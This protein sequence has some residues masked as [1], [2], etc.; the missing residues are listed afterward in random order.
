MARRPP[1]RKETEMI[2]H[3]APALLAALVAAVP[4]LAQETGT[5]MDGPMDGPM[6]G[7]M[8]MMMFETLDADGDGKVTV[9]EIEAHRL[10]AV[11]ALDADGN[12]LISR[13]ELIAAHVRMATERA[14]RMADRRLAAQDA[15]GD[16]QLSAAEL[17]APPMPPKR[18]FERADTDGDG[19]ISEAEFEAAM[20]RMGD[21]MGKGGRGG[22]HGHGWWGDDDN[23]GDE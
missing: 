8:G 18:L 6:G 7:P 2:R 23:G 5:P 15:N 14:A 10:A 22:R 4:A 11:V 19:A 1:T 12:G 9:A 16:G 13:D 3:T 20:E 21:R 17:A